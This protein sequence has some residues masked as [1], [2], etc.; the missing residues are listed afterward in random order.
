MSKCDAC[1][2]NVWPCPAAFDAFAMR[3]ARDGKDAHA[4]RHI[5]AEWALEAANRANRWSELED[6]ALK[7]ELG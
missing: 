6:A 1:T 5:M 7:E 3:L 2:G 4:V